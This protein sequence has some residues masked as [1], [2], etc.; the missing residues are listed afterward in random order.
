MVT[1]I[2]VT[3]ELAVQ[4]VDRGRYRALRPQVSADGGSRAP[5][6]RCSAQHRAWSLAREPDHSA[7]GP[8]PAAGLRARARF[9]TELF[10]EEDSLFEAFIETVHDVVELPK[11]LSLAGLKLVDFRSFSRRSSVSLVLMSTLSH[12]ICLPAS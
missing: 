11:Q 8:L 4:A 1:V 10:H 6:V 2:D 9:W 5:G 7:V 12:W 3:Q